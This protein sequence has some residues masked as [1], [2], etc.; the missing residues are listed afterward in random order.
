M[1]NTMTLSKVNLTKA[2]EDSFKLFCGNEE[3]YIEALNALGASRQAEKVKVN[4]VLFKA[5]PT[6]MEA[7]SICSGDD[8][9]REI[10][11]DTIESGTKVYVEIDGTP[12]MLRDTALASIYERL[13][14]GGDVLNE[15]PAGLLAQHLND[16]AQYAVNEGLAIANNGKLEAILGMKYTLVP[17][18]E[19]MISASAYFATGENPARFIAGSYSHS[20]ADAMWKTGE[21]KMD[22]PIDTGL[23]DVV[24]EQNVVVSTSDCGRKAITISPKMKRI[25]DKHGLEFC[26]PLKLE[27]DGKASVEEFEKMLKLIDKRFADANDRICDMASTYLNHPANVLLGMLKWLK[28]PAKY[29]AQVYERRK[30]MWDGIEKTSYDVYASLS[31]VLSLILGE[32]QN[33]Y[34]LAMYQERF[35]RALRFD[36]RGYDLPGIYGYQDKL[37]GAKG[38]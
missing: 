9:L 10:V 12:F 29:G 19:L 15:I 11:M 30:I 17:V 8:I 35:A 28:I 16:Y 33:T 3:D 5:M 7:Y 1:E 20:Y 27:H 32:E 2:Y 22:A 38:V 13:R 36:Y 14:I 37:I 34:N 23:G 18:E 26:L 31:E 25:D 4:S 6:P 24:F 21:C